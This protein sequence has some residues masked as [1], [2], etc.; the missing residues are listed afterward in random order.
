MD[1]QAR[2]VNQLIDW[3]I[4]NKRAAANVQF[5]SDGRSVVN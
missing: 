5:Y 1:T 2:I 4:D 3:P